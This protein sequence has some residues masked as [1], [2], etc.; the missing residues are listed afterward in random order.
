MLQLLQNSNQSN[1]RHSSL[2]FE[3][4]LWK[5]LVVPY[6]ATD[7]PRALRGSGAMIQLLPNLNMNTSRQSSL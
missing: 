5:A 2:N 4:K 1:N 3:Q 6:M 7:S